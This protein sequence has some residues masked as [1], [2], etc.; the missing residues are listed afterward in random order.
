MLAISTADVDGDRAGQRARL[1]GHPSRG[2][3]LGALNWELVTEW[4]GQ[5]RVTIHQPPTRRLDRAVVVHQLLHDPG[6]IAARAAHAH[7]DKA[8]VTLSSRN[9][10][11][12]SRDREA[13]RA[14]DVQCLRII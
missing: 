2:R 9:A 8:W 10:E 12:F 14:G 4:I 6:L 3:A 1:V 11:S 7:V 13:V 5:T